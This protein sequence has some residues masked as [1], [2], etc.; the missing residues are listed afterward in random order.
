VGVAVVA[1][2]KRNR[3][4]IHMGAIRFLDDME[5]V[6]NR[7]GEDQTVK[8]NAGDI[9]GAL[10][11]QV[12]DEG[13][14]NVELRDGGVF[15]GILASLFENMGNKVPTI[16]VEQE[17]EPTT[18]SV[19]VEEP[20]PVSVAVEEPTPVSA[21]VEEPTAEEDAEDLYD[22]SDLDELDEEKDMFD[23][24]DEDEIG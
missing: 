21:V 2:V 15:V 24:S 16:Y 10:A 14:A 4:I 12:D 1:K 23:E 5:L 6:V 18:T 9:Y 13:Y 22:L 19:A 17:E 11:I 7:D 8:I 20:T 3:E